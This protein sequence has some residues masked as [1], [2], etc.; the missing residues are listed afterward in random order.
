MDCG[1]GEH[2]VMGMKD[3]LF[4]RGVLFDIAKLKDVSFLGDEEAIPRLT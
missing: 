1:A 2:D 4:T 3:G